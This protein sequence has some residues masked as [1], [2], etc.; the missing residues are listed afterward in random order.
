MTLSL[1]AIPNVTAIGRSFRIRVGGV[2]MAV[3]ILAACTQT[4]GDTGSS[5]VSTAELKSALDAHLAECTEIHGL[6]PLELFGIGENELAAGEKEWLECAYQGV[7]AIMVPATKFPDMYRQLMADSRSMTDLVEKGEMT[8][9]QRRTVMQ[10]AIAEIENAEIV[11]L[12]RGSAVTNE[13]LDRAKTAEMRSAFV[14]M[15]TM[16]MPRPVR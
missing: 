1:Q 3:A 15:R 14:G 11:S 16:T 10:A 6:N 2:A 5:K 9:T 8:R 7:E 12:I 13:K 4:A